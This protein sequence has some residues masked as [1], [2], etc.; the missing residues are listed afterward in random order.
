[1]ESQKAKPIIYKMFEV[2]VSKAIAIGVPPL[3]ITFHYSRLKASDS[4]I[5]CSSNQSA[6]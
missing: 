5:T 4:P 2:S 1:M 3:T 6:N